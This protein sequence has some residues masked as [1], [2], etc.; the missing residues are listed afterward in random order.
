MMSMRQWERSMPRSAIIFSFALLIGTTLVATA[1][2]SSNPVWLFSLFGVKGEALGEFTL[3]LTGEPADTCVSGEWK[4]ARVLR[5]SVQWL[6]DRLE[7]NDY[8]P[9]YII[10]GG[11]FQVQLNP[12]GLCDAYTTLSGKISGNEARGEYLSEGMFGGEALGTFRASRQ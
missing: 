2:P 11:S 3:E 4:K 12:P 9:T 7:Q 1:A 8:F 6:A 10:E 5:N